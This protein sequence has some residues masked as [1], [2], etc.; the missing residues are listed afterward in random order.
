MTIGDGYDGVFRPRYGCENT[1]TIDIT[2]TEG[3]DSMKNV[4]IPYDLFITLVRY[5]MGLDDECTDIIQR[6]LEQKMDAL[7]CH[8]WYSKYKTAST[9]EERENARKMYLD[10]Q[11]IQDSFR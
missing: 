2:V 1:D 6:G 10:K 3:M 7:V 11:G 5:H 8:E 4:Q 9:E